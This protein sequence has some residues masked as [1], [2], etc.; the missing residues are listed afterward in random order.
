MWRRQEE[1]KP[2]PSAAE[3]PPSPQPSVVER[4]ST[5]PEPRAERTTVTRSIAIRGEVTGGEDLYIDGE[6]QGTIRLTENSLTIGP[7][8][9]VAAEIEA[10]EIVIEGQVKGNLRG[11]ERV[12]LRQTGSVAGDIV[13][14]RIAIEEGA[15]FRGTVEIARP[16][17]ARSAAK[18]REA[19]AAAGALIGVRAAAKNPV[20]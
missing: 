5:K 4:S 12:V 6:V 2:S 14:A 11:R 7:N 10:R 15:I 16:E 20:Q 8:G 19:V 1:P 9:R 13:T 17:E 3:T 18:P